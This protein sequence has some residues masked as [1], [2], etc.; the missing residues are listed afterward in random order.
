MLTRSSSTDLGVLR[1]KL[2]GDVLYLG[3]STD[4]D[5]NAVRFHKFQMQMIQIQMIQS[6][7]K[8]DDPDD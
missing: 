5:L 8:P 1:R 4:L 2:A 6:R 3:L 7:S